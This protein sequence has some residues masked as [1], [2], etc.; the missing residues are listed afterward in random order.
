MGLDY[1]TNYSGQAFGKT[2]S[3]EEYWSQM[4]E[5]LWG[6]CHSNSGTTC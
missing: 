3:D 6:C 5:G 4:M 2:S 1:V